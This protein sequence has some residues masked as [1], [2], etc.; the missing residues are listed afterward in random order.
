MQ[1][2]PFANVL[3]NRCLKNFAIFTGKH[4]CKSLFLTKW[5]SCR[6]LPVNIAKFL[7]AAFFVFTELL[8]WLLLQMFC[9]ILYIFKKTLLNSYTLHNCFILKPKITLTRF[10]FKCHTLSFVLP[11][12]VTRCH[13]FYHSMSFVV[14]RCNSL[15]LVVTRCTTCLSFYKR[16]NPHV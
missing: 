5:H 9:F 10:H 11:H 4:Q 15:S 6:Y 7:R 14:T 16:S 1:K 13:S 8:R 2:Q 12:V 3:Q